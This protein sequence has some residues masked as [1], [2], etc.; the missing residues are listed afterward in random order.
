MPF[1]D[2][3]PRLSHR[4]TPLQSLL[5]H[6]INQ[7]C[8]SACQSASQSVRRNN[9][10]GDGH[11]PLSTSRL[12]PQ[13]ALQLKTVRALTSLGNRLAVRA[14]NLSSTASKTA[15]SVCTTCIQQAKIGD[16]LLCLFTETRGCIQV[17]CMRMTLREH[18]Y[19]N[20]L[21]YKRCPGLSCC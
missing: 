17:P 1:S 10:T 8:I 14:T 16:T 19:L 13:P 9:Q 7:C 2:S 5:S 3:D 4:S 20:L 21:L 12:R 11:P 6:Y 15:S 18:T